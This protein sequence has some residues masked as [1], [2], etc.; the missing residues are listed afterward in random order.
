[1]LDN[2]QINACATEINDCLRNAKN[3]VA[4]YTKASIVK[5]VELLNRVHDNMKKLACLENSSMQY[6]V[7]IKVDNREYSYSDWMNKIVA[8]NYS[9]I[10][11]YLEIACVINGIT[12]DFDEQNMRVSLR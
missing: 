5:T 12:L 9:N 4:Q 10:L 11:S 6:S 1:M 7:K 2:N 8:P 3:F